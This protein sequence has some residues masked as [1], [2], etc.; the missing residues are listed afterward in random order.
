MII[1]RLWLV[2]GKKLMCNP[3]IIQPAVRAE[4]A[5]AVTVRYFW[6]PAAALAPTV[7]RFQ[8]KNLA[9]MVSRHDGNKKIGIRPNNMA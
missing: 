6:T 7:R 1:Y 9:H 2:H 5:R 4:S 8:N 3:F